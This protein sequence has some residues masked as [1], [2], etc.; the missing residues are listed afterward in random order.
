MPEGSG[1]GIIDH[2][3]A[4]VVDADGRLVGVLTRTSALRASLYRPALDADGR[5]AVAAALG[6]IARYGTALYKDSQ[7]YRGTMPDQDPP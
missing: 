7:L 1:I 6:V 4:P 3:I 2:R 5:L